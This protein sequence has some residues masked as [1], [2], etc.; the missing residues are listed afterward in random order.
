MCL[1]LFTQ[2]CIQ[3]AAEAEVKATRACEE[4]QRKRLP[5]HESLQKAQMSLMEAQD[6]LERAQKDEEKSAEAVD[7]EMRKVRRLQVLTSAKQVKCTSAESCLANLMSCINQDEWDDF[8]RNIARHR[9]IMHFVQLDAVSLMSFKLSF[10]RSLLLQAEKLS[11]AQ[12]EVRRTSEAF[13]DVTEQ[14]NFANAELESIGPIAAWLRMEE[15]AEQAVKEAENVWASRGDLSA[16]AQTVSQLMD[17]A[18]AARVDAALVPSSATEMFAVNVDVMYR[19]TILDR[20]KLLSN[21]Y[22]KYG[23]TLQVMPAKKHV[24][25]GYEVMKYFQDQSPELSA[26][27]I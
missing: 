19:G 15:Q 25:H 10:T 21:Y 3:K 20:R 13:E 18:E 2:T 23:E 17:Q 14:L 22:I 5:L 26:M 6:E 24:Q 8:A 1:D 9:H 16:A 7:V 11:Y 27:C 4:K 12:E